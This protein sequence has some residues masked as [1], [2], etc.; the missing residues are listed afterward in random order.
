[1]KRTSPTKNRILAVCPQC[2]KVR[3]VLARTDAEARRKSALRCQ[4][5]VSRDRR[6][7]GQETILVKCPQCGVYRDVV[8]RGPVYNAKAAM[9]PCQLCA[10]LMAAAKRLS[11]VQGREVRCPHCGET[12]I[13]RLHPG[14][15]TDRPC[16]KCANKVRA[17]MVSGA[18]TYDA[19]CGAVMVS[20]CEGRCEQFLTCEHY[21]DCLD[22]A[23]TR[24]W[25]GWRCE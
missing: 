18:P 10:S 19:P 14:E 13:L 12:R 17:G 6:K 25:R 3:A 24:N 16:M 5:C 4:E 8:S 20:R 22:V 1:M 7:P 9:K 2:G 15:T 21:E 11:R 23:A